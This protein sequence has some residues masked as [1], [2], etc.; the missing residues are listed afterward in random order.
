MKV[1][2]GVWLCAIMGVKWKGGKI[3]L[4]HNLRGLG[5]CGVGISH[6]YEGLGADKGN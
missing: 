5:K 1:G 6:S 3:L 2:W 4:V